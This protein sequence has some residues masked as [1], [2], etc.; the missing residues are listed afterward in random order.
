MPWSGENSDNAV[1]IVRLE[2]VLTITQWLLTV[3]H[4][5]KIMEGID[6]EQ[7]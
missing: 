7:N 4:D 2:R 6:D 1:I 5:I 3:D